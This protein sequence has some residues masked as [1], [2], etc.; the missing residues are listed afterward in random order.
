MNLSAWRYRRILA[1]DGGPISEIGIRDC[2]S[3]LEI[4]TMEMAGFEACATL[5]IELKPE[6]F[7][8]N[9]VYGNCDGSGWGLYQ[10]EA[11]YKA[12]SESIERWAFYSTIGSTNSNVFGF[13]LDPSTT[14]MAA[15][16]GLTRTQA[17][18]SACLEAIERWSLCQ[19][20]EGRLSAAQLPLGALPRGTSGIKICSPWPQVKIVVLYSSGETPYRCYGFA[21]DYS[22]ANA[23]GHARIEQLRNIA[24][25]KAYFSKAVKNEIPVTDSNLY[26]RR[27]LYFSHEGFSAF[28]ERVRS[29]L[30]NGPCPAEPKLIVDSEI[31]GPWTRYATVWRCLFDPCGSKETMASDAYFL[32]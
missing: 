19:W 20:W 13:D 4:Q 6:R 8:T 26:E 31:I 16:P 9:K 25:V 24:A 17:R 7:R 2:A 22:L 10:H 23:I 1:R 30:A 11:V 15:F 18:N 28:Y 32:F 5:R 3:I 27:L 14:G 21:A 12:I 29:S